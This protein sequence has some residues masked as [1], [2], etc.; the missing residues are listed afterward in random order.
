[1]ARQVLGSRGKRK[2]AESAPVLATWNTDVIKN[3]QSGFEYQFFNEHEVREKQRASLV[4]LVDFETGE[5]TVHQIPGW[6]VVQ[7]ENGPEEAGGYRPDEGKP[8]DTT[9]RHGPHVAM[10]IP[11]EAWNLLQKAQEQRADSYE[12]RLRG[13]HTEEWSTSGQA[14]RL[15]PREKGVRLTESF[16]PEMVGG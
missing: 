16:S 13:G 2:D 5:T 1:M 4:R 6:Q 10:R 8:L 15:M 12:Q 9:L 11:T 14:R 7:H 3:K